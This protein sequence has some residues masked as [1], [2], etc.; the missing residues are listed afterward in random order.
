MPPL[1]GTII[2]EN[3][4]VDSLIPDP[5]NP[6]RHS[7]EHINAVDRSISTFGWTVPIL[8]DTHIRA[9]H[10]RRLA[11][12]QIYGRGERIRLPND[13]ELPAGTV[14]VIDCTGWSEAQIRAYVIADN[15]LTIAGEWDEDRLKAQI[16][17]LIDSDIDMSALGFEEAEI[18]RMMRQARGNSDPNEVPAALANPVSRLGDLWML[19]RHRVL[20]GD[21]TDPAAVAAFLEGMKTGAL[22]CTDPPYGIGYEYHEHED[23]AGEANALLVEKAFALAPKGKVWTPGLMNLA[24]DL[25]RFG[26]AKMAIWHK[27]FAAA[28]S[29]LGGAS[30]IEPVLILEPPRRKLANDYLHFGTDREELNGRMLRDYHPCPKPVALYEHLIQAFCP[31]RGEV[32][33]PFAGSGTT[34]IAAESAGRP[35]RAIEIDPAYVDVVIMRWQ[36]FTGGLAKLGQLTFEEVAFERGVSL[37]Q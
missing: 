10:A 30:T 6:R 25:M 3:R 11:A 20:C 33:E 16:A 15:Q 29:G 36:G 17:A 26:A 12:R 7:A 24:R 14:P 21:S 2:V 35:C 31:P 19:G 22:T 32:Y 34:L 5:E 28:G 8:S 18:E 9:G 1:A 37:G 27:G 13:E 23:E 4:P